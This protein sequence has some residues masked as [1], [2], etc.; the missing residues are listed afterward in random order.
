MTAVARCG[1]VSISRLSA[2]RA[3]AASMGGEFYRQL[4]K[5]PEDRAVPVQQLTE[6]YEE[7]R[8]CYQLWADN[9]AKVP[10]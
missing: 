4:A 5:P 9:A 1:S 2:R 3:F 10:Y 7:A 6:C 8:A